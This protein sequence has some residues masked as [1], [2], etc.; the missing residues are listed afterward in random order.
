M[1]GRPDITTFSNVQCYYRAAEN[2]HDIQ[3]EIS[4]G[5]YEAG[6]EVTICCEENGK[7]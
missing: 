4:D 3:K 1:K 2:P 5:P 7:G 6:K